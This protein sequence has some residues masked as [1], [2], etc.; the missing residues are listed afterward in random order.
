MEPGFCQDWS[1][2][3]WVSKSLDL[4]ACLSF[5][6]ETVIWSLELALLM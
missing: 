1:L 4:D 5:E 6:S 2:K 3:V